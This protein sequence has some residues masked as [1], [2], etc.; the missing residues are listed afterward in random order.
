[1]DILLAVEVSVCLVEV[2]EVVEVQPTPR[3]VGALDVAVL[4]GD[5]EVQ[6]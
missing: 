5:K 4:N 3:E 2:A 6:H 1:M